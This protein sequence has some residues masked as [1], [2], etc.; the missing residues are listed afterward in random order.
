MTML[1]ESV[2]EKLFSEEEDINVYTIL[3]GASVPDLPMALHD[4]QPEH[5]C[6]YRGELEPDIEE[7]APY[8]VRLERDAEFTDWI[9]EKGWG[10]HWGIFATAR[11]DIRIMRR[12]FR[13]FLRVYDEEA[14]PLL[15]RYYDP[16]V[17][18]TYLPTCNETELSTMFGPVI[19]YFSEDEDKQMLR[20]ELSSGELKKEKITLL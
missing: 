13:T 18:R 4:H 1:I 11:S 9:I 5:F 10:S 15:F 2:T 6:L 8:L 12:H 3:D 17:L 20:F 19:H 16:R 14:R 7:V